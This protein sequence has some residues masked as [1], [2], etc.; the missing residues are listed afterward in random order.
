[1]GRG[2]KLDI[3]FADLG[4]GWEADN[5]T[6]PE[7]DDPEPLAPHEHTIVFKKEKRRGRVVTLAG[8]FSLSSK[9]QKALLGRVKK[10]LGCGGTFKK[11][12]LEV[13]G[14]R[15]QALRTFLASEK[16]RMKR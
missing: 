8:P 1:M 9:E 10:A 7:T 15:Q 5:K 6:G 2:I 16:F 12:W 3:D 4:E 11:G 13:Q 14:E